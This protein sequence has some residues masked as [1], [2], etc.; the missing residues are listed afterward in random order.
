VKG[1]ERVRDPIE[2][3]NMALGIAVLA[4]A[5]GWWRMYITAEDAMLW[6][7]LSAYRLIVPTIAVPDWIAAAL[8]VVM[9]LAAACQVLHVHRQYFTL[10]QFPLLMANYLLI[11]MKPP[12][13]LFVLIVAHLAFAISFALSWWYRERRK[14][15]NVYRYQYQYLHTNA[16]LIVILTYALAGVAKLNTGFFDLDTTVAASFVWKA[17]SPFNWLVGKIA[18]SDPSTMTSLWRMY[19]FLGIGATLT[20]EFGVP[21]CLLF[22]RL[23][24]VALA[25]GLGFHFLLASYSAL[26]FSMTMIA[27]YIPVLEL[28]EYRDFVDNYALRLSRVRAI[29]VTAACSYL[30]LIHFR[31]EVIADRLSLWDVLRVACTWCVG[32]VWIAMLEYACRRFSVRPDVTDTADCVASLET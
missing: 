3:F 31:S 30:L 8:Y 1:A 17:V 27:L 18:G 2:A 16:L 10:L 24:P 15:T 20:I 11:G 9:L 12:N 5:A 7:Y 29:I 32:Y 23:R 26:D 14:H 6:N 21:V 22:S 13:H 19:A 4:H 25:A 28:H